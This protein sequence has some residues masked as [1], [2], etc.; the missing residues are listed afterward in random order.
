M[1][2]FKRINPV[3]FKKHWCELKH[4]LVSR[5]SAIEYVSNLSA[6]IRDNPEG[7]FEEIEVVSRHISRCEK[8]IDDL[9][10]LILVDDTLATAKW[11][12]VDVEQFRRFLYQIGHMVCCEEHYADHIKAGYSKLS[13]TAGEEQR[14]EIIDEICQL[15]VRLD[16]TRKSRQEYINDFIAPEV[17]IGEEKAEKLS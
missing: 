6:E 16:E 14:Q 8:L 1:V 5:E 2:S 4:Y 7:T 12:R 15:I 10:G 17:E 3:A 11:V 13:S 9:L